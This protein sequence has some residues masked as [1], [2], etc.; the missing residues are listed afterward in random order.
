MAHPD[1]IEN[2]DFFAS[3]R[4]K[5]LA[6]AYPGTTRDHRLRRIASEGS[7]YGDPGFLPYLERCEAERVKLAAQVECRLADRLREGRS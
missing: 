6:Q 2:W 7:L 4:E 1:R 3:P 5:E